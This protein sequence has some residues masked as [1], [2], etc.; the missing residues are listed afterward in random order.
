MIRRCF[1]AGLLAGTLVTI[2]VLAA[3]AAVAA[4]SIRSAGD[5]GITGSAAVTGSVSAAK[6]ARAAGS[7]SAARAADA[8]DAA[9][10]ASWRV[11]ASV[12]A[13][14]QRI[15]LSDVAADAA[16]DAWAIGSARMANQASFQPVIEHWNGRAWQQVTLPA[17]VLKTLGTSSVHATIGASAPANV[18]AF[19]NGGYWLHWNGKRWTAGRLARPAPAALGPY[20]GSP[21]VFSPSD[22]WA[23]GDYQ[24]RSGTL[25][26]YG[27]HF[28]G[29][30]WQPFTTSGH[31]GFAAESA[32]SPTDIWALMN[33]GVSGS[34]GAL[35]RWNGSQWAHVPLPSALTASATLYSVYA[36]SD[37]DVWVG[38]KAKRT[39]N[40]VVA[41]WDG[42]TW[43]TDTFGPVKN[44]SPDALVQMVSDGQG[45]IWALASCTLGSCWRL[46]HYTGGQ[47]H[48]PVQ[49]S[50]NGASMFVAEL[51]HVPGTT[52]VWA[53][54]GSTTGT[55][56]GGFIALQG[57]VPA[58]RAPA[59]P[60]KARPRP[61]ARPV[62][63]T[64]M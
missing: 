50:I 25:V 39:G 2:P 49:P 64:N 46:W 44:F 7:A 22:V 4:G 27:V 43:T 54:G 26:P 53:A 13:R 38:G 31:L 17:S 24:T 28:N 8:A 20:V 57:T 30:D 16:N 9:A 35:T 55:V 45:G 11:T 63:C 61:P 3:T 60:R 40:G 47:W 62:T 19:G 34:G 41:H 5:G 37:S 42:A 32:V 15:Q 23:F 6:V 12:Q 36:H 33:A 48:G 58:P 52:A 59:P 1:G 14:N 29:Q 56:S 18:W 10:M 51:A 21:L